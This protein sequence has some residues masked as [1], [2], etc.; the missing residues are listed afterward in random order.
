MVVVGYLE[1][2]L[3]GL[4]CLFVGGSWMCMVLVFVWSCCSLIRRL[5]CCSL[6]FCGTCSSMFFVWVVSW[7]IS[8]SSDSMVL[9]NTLV[10]YILFGVL[11]IGIFILLYV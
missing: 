3:G 7:C 10:V 9:C 11:C 8:S 2:V 4:L 6:Y 1:R 5:L